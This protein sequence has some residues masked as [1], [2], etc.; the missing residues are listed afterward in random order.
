MFFA[1]LIVDSG[2]D[3]VFVETGIVTVDRAAAWVG[4]YGHRLRDDECYGVQKGWRNFIPGDPLRG[5]QGNLLARLAGRRSYGREVS[6]QHV[7]GGHERGK[8]IR[9]GTLSRPLI[10]AEEKQL[11]SDDMP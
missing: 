2:D 9:I 4:R 3:E 1:L 10:P 6:L 11:V 7:S 5:T 8:R